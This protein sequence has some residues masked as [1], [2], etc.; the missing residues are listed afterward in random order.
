MRPN[1]YSSPVQTPSYAIRLRPASGILPIAMVLFLLP[2]IAFASPPDP[3][4]IE[5]IYDG[6]DGDD[7]V[8]LI[9]DNVAGGGL[10][11]LQLPPPVPLTETPFDFKPG[12]V[13]SLQADQ[14]T[15]GPPSNSHLPFHFG[16]ILQVR[17][18]FR[19]HSLPLDVASSSDRLP[20]QPGTVAMDGPPP[21]GLEREEVDA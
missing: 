4:W 19:T 12:A 6:A 14:Q 13:H 7:I 16:H 2:G 8:T 3:S 11:P 20:T 10:F 17:A 21:V 1:F 18:P 9:T 15:R 5:G